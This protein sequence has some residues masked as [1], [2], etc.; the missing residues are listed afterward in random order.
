MGVASEKAG[1]DSEAPAA[2]VDIYGAQQHRKPHRVGLRKG[3]A[4]DRK[5]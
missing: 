2:E 5:S 1:A 3:W 4:I